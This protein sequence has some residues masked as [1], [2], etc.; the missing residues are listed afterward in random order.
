V[1]ADLRSQDLLPAELLADLP[2]ALGRTRAAAVTAT[3]KPKTWPAAKSAAAKRAA[4]AAARR[5]EGMHEVLDTRCAGRC[6]SATVSGFTVV[7]HTCLTA[8]GHRLPHFDRSVTPVRLAHLAVA[9]RPKAELHGSF[10]AKAP[11]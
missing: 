10:K 1:R 4:E 6:V 9:P 5:A 11:R 2:A 8:L 3:E 7:H